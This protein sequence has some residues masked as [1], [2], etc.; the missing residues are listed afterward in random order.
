MTTS[1]DTTL[2]IEGMTCQGCVQSVTRVL[3]A[4]PGVQ[5]VTVS[6]ERHAADLRYDPQQV[7]PEAMRAAVEGAGFDVR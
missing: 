5:S 6:L 4:L 3:Q 2:Q 7:T 1:S